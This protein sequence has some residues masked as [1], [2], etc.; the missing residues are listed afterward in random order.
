MMEVVVTTVALRCAELQSNHHHQQ[1]NITIHCQ[2]Q[3]WRHTSLPLVWGW[4][5]LWLW[6]FDSCNT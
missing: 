1:T 4:Q 5:P 3:D 2:K 6:D